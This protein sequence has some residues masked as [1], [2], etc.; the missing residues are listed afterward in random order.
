MQR[1]KQYNLTFVKD[2]VNWTKD[3]FD[4]FYKADPV[5]VTVL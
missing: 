5:W 1:G 2:V 4:A 3:F